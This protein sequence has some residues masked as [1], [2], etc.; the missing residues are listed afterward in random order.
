M[1]EPAFTIEEID[2]LVAPYALYPDALLAQILVAST[3]PLQIVKADR[4][5]DEM[6][7][8]SDEELS[9]ALEAE[10]WDP[11]VLVVLSGFPTVIQRMA[12]N[13]EET[14]DLGLAMAEQDQDVLASVQWLR[15]QAQDTG[16]LTSNEAQ[17]VEDDGSGIRIE[18]ANPDVIYVPTYDT[19][20]AFTS[21]ATAAPLIVQPGRGSFSSALSNPLVAGAIGFGAGLLVSELFGDEDDDF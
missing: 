21:P 3:F 15:E 9:E 19:S 17:I 14:E 2:A 20:A 16:Y 4:V 12:D 13:L 18:P 5:I 1:E 6:S 10:E 8:M 11:S 7:T